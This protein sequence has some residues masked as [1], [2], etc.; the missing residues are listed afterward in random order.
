MLKEDVLIRKCPTCDV[1]LTYSSKNACLGA[2]KTNSTCRACADKK[3]RERWTSEMVKQE[4]QRMKTLIADP[5]SIWH[6][7]TYKQHKS[8]GLKCAHKDPEAV[9]NTQ[10]WKENQSRVALH[11]AATGIH[12][13]Q[14]L[15]AETKRAALEKSRRTRANPSSRFQARVKFNRTDAGRKLVSAA[16]KKAWRNPASKLRSVEYL[17]KLRQIL[18]DARKR[19]KRR[20]SSRHERALAALLFALDPRFVLNESGPKVS[21]GPYHPDIVDTERRIVVEFYGD[22]SHSHPD[23]YPADSWN[24]L[25]HKTAGAVREFDAKRNDFIRARGWKVIVV[26]ETEWNAS[27]DAVVNRVLT[28]TS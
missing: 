23:M 25:S 3:R 15:S 28:E 19:V 18:T 8:E 16:A 21:V 13:F 26:W 5:Q 20:H 6:T 10:A 9:W 1:T 22:Y 17:T 2:E 14:N 27:Q 12:P 4:S 7:S 11:Q 24:A